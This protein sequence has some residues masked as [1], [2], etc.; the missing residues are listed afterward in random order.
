MTWSSSTLTTLKTTKSRCRGDFGD[1]YVEE[2]LDDGVAA[3]DVLAD[4]CEFSADEGGE[5]PHNLLELL[6]QAFGVPVAGSHLVC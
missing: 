4:M 6:T 1:A 2:A 5:C 3:E